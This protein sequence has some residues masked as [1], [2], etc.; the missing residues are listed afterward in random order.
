MNTSSENKSHIPGKDKALEDSIATMQSKLASI[1]FSIEERSWLNPIPHAWSVHIRDKD[2]PLLFTNGKGATK[3]AAL[4][5]ALG[6]FF[7][8]LA[9]NYFWADYYLAPDLS[10]VLL[11]S[12]QNSAFMHYPNEKWVTT[13]EALVQNGWTEELSQFY[14]PETP[15]TPKQLIDLNSGATHEGVCTL[16]YQCVRTN[17]THYFPVNVIGNLYVSNGMSA[18]NNRHEGRVQALSEILERYVKFQI[19]AEGISLPDIPESVLQRYPTVIAGIKSL[20]DAGFSL[21]LKDASIEGQYPV[22]NITLLNPEDQSCFASFGAHPRFEVAL[23]R[24]LTELLQGRGL[25]ALKGFSEPSFD[26]DDIASPENLE[27]H[28][29]DSSGLISWDFLSSQPDYAFND[30]NFEGSTEE[31]YHWLCEK[32]HQQGHD[33][34]VADYD[35][36]DTYAC[37]ILVPGMSEIY[38]VE[39]LIWENNNAGIPLQQN[40]IQLTQAQTREEQLSLI[41]H[42]LDSIEEQDIPDQ[43]PLFELI[44]FA[45]QPDSLLATTRIGE[46][47]IIFG[48]LTEQLDVAHEGCEWIKH[49]GHLPKERTQLYQCVQTLL[50]MDEDKP[51]YQQALKQLY[52]HSILDLAIRLERKEFDLLDELIAALRLE[53]NQLHQQLLTAYDKVNACKIKAL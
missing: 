8:R 47:K 23:E 34:Y 16:P 40:L 39:D 14:A 32:I 46:L 12:E 36:L 41:Q 51:Y 18:G 25:D 50:D 42:M 9:T 30:W 2:C 33:I 37:R 26:L 6:E 17:Q 21:L 15:L 5:S 27:T 24:T 3:K 29:I 49:F 1:G 43:R 4:A 10:Q 20:E 52:P 11:P 19:I 38:P 45:A 13:Q 7:E 48:L 31:E 53:D 28:F 44:G 22:I 35:H